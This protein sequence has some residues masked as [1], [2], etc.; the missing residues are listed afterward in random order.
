M[1]VPAPSNREQVLSCPLNPPQARLPQTFKPQVATGM[2]PILQLRPDLGL[3]ISAV[4]LRP[5]VPYPPTV[6]IPACKYFAVISSKYDVIVL[7]SVDVVL[8]VGVGVVVVVVDVVFVVVV[9]VVIIGAVGE[10]LVEVVVVV[11][12]E[13]LK[14]HFWMKGIMMVLGLTLDVCLELA[15]QS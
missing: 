1:N 14:H 7:P 8:V 11:V 12:V 5:L 2:S 6:R 15:E 4:L 10:V 13:G 3:K 9:V